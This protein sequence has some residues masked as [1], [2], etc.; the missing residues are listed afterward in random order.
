MIKAG[1]LLYAMFLIIVVA[2][3]SSSFVLVNYVNDAFA[4]RVIK[5]KQLYDDVHSGI[6]YGLT[7]YNN[8]QL[9]EEVE[10]DLF[11]DGKHKVL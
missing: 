5:K 10:T 6:N 2:I 3:M 8:L 9:N 7:F 1:A 11:D 4:L